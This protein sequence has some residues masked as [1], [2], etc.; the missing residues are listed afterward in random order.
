[1]TDTTQPGVRATAVYRGMDRAALDAAYNNSAA[2]TDSAEWI[3]NWRRRSMT[4]RVMPGAQ[5]DIPYGKQERARF[6]YLPAGVPGGPLFVFIHGGYWQRNDK[7]IFS[8]VAAGPHAHGVNV[9]VLGYT[10]APMARLS[11]IVREI[12]QALTFLGRNA[13]QLGFSPEKIYAGGWSAGG[14]LATIAC[15]HQLVRGALAISGIFDLEPIALT[16]INDR[17]RLDRNEIETLSPLRLLRHGTAPLRL[18]VGS[19][20]LTELKRQSLRFKEAADD[21]SLPITLRIMPGHHHFSILDELAKP[22]GVLISE[23]I[24]LL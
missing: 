4:I 5:L 1:V 2:V 11:D 3:A 9:A 10:L 8:F 6:D 15:Q 13:K 22:D 14:H 17:L 24:H 7:D 18:A 23:L 21:L 19:D 16:Y 12:E 20:E